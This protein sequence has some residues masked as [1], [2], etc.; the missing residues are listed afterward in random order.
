MT[1][2]VLDRRQEFDER[3]KDY[4]IRSLM[5][6][7]EALR[8]Y[9]W[10]CD[11]YNDQGQE[12]A[13]VGFGWSHE[14]S[15]RPKVIRTD[16]SGAQAIYNRA[17]QLDQWPGEDYEGTSVLAG[18]KAVQER[19][20]SKG[21]TVMP[22]YRWAFG[23]HDVALTLGFKGP[24]VLGVDWYSNMWD[25]AEDGFL[26]ADGD[27]VGGHCILA[28]GVRVVKKDPLIAAVPS[29]IDM[30]K[31]WVLLHNSWGTGW[32]NGGTARLRLRGLDK[33]LRAGGDACVP[34]IR[35]AA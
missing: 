19:L 10:S 26:H 32:G 14:L 31:S 25:P 12:G 15:A 7:M 17:R 28:R 27:L 3:S 18:A 24:V 30:D 22:E 35:N 16:A 20:N 4:P 23:W 2:R 33:L 11:V 34:V 21:V 5:E 13:C 9:T 1:Q 8:S 6:G 29:N